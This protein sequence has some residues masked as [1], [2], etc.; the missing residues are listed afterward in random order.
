MLV[1]DRH[2]ERVHA[3]V[4]A[5]RDEL[6][7]HDGGRAVLGRVAEVVLPRAAERGVDDELLRL[8]VVGRRRA[9][10]G[11]IR[12][13][14][15]LGHGEGAGHLE[16]HDV[17][18]EACG[19]GTRCRGAGWR[20]TNS[21]HCTPDLICRLGS[22]VT[23]S[24]KPAMLPP[25]SSLPPTASGRRGARRRARRAACSWPEH[26]LAVL[27]HRLAVDALHLGARRELTRG[28]PHVRPGA[29]QLPAELLEIDARGPELARNGDGSGVDAGADRLVDVLG[30]WSGERQCQPSGSSHL[31]VGVCP[32]GTSGARG[33]ETVRGGIT[34]P[35]R[36]PARRVGG[37]RQKVATG[38][39]EVRQRG[40][41]PQRSG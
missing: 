21:P 31:A 36:M 14:A 11:D 8:L 17:G 3:V 33:G 24:S 37:I 35:E 12:A 4:D 1:A 28:E 18:Q 22:A 20:P 26:A 30:G 2:V 32:H 39:G 15:G 29:E 38:L 13:V 9:D 34:K 23:S 40:G 16:G 27:L 5:L 6:R 10:G 25:W 41:R 19:G 7:E